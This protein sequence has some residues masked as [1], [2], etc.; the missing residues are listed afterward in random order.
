M[1]MNHTHNMIY[2]H[3]YSMNLWVPF[4]LTALPI[5]FPGYF[6]RIADQYLLQCLQLGSQFFRGT[7]GFCCL[8]SFLWRFYFRIV[9]ALV[10]LDEKGNPRQGDCDAVFLQHGLN[11]P[12]GLTPK[13]CLQNF[14]PIWRQFT[15]EWWC[16]FFSRH[17]CFL[18]QP[19]YY[20]GWFPDFKFR[21]FSFMIR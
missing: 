5:I 10:P 7:W 8:R 15:L 14:V 6:G 21:H 2:C 12:Q 9:F 4:L 1:P 20:T 3:L 16:A 18:P 11:F 19:S 17:S 13:P